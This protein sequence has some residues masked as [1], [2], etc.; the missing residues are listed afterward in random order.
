LPPLIFNHNSGDSEPITKAITGDTANL[1]KQQK[2]KEL[3]DQLIT[4][5]VINQ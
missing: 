1:L 4:K 3:R 2:K 5:N